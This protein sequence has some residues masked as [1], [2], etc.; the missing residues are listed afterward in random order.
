MDM[1]EYMII[2]S[3]LYTGS[4]L[5]VVITFSICYMDEY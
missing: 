3:I 1:E 2:I 4:Y 5:Y